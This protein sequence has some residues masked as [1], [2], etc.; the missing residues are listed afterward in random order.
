MT[1]YDHTAGM[2]EFPEIMGML[3]AQEHFGVSRQY[4]DRLV[5]AGKLRHRKT[6]AGIIFLKSDLEALEFPRAKGKRRQ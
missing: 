3:D 2:A 5:R 6:S 1:T 4:L